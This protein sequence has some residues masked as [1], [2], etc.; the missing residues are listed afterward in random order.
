MK[1]PSQNR[2]QYVTGTL[3]NDAWTGVGVL[4]LAKDLSIVNRRGYG[5][6]D[7]KGVPLVFRCR[8]T[9]EMQDV[10]GVGYGSSLDASGSSTLMMKGC[11]NNWVYRNA[12]VKWHEARDNMW[13]KAGVSKKDLGWW[14]KYVRYAWLSHNES[15]I[16]PL[17]GDGAAF[18]GGT[19]DLSTFVDMVDNEY[20]LALNAPGVDEDSTHS[21]TVIN[22]AH[23]YLSSRPTVPTDSN[24]ESSEVPAIYSHLVQLLSPTNLESGSEEAYIRADA[25]SEQDNPPYEVFA[26][27]TTAHDITEPVE[28]GRIVTRLDSNASGSMIVDIPFG[29]SYVSARHHDIADADITNSNLFTV[30]V[31]KITP[32]Q[33]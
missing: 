4:N 22:P 27:E 28:L 32:M 19:W 33:G 31:L 20:K 18:A 5:A 11:Q 10:A 8:V 14:S 23:S 1:F 25:Q 29:L 16:S 7:E 6:T 9:M 2:L 26:T 24:L 3:S 30:E 17:D 21:A 13:K 12:G 15:Y